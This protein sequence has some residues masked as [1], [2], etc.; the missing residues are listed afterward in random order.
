MLKKRDQ[1]QRTNP[2]IPNEV[3]LLAPGTPSSLGADGL[4][5]H[6]APPPQACDARK[7]LDR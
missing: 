5:S 6:Q 2:I 1:K 7:L 4:K 3:G